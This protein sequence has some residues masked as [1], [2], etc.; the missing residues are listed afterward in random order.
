MNM[1]LMPCRGQVSG[2]KGELQ[3]GGSWLLVQPHFFSPW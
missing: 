1:G 3:T 2:W